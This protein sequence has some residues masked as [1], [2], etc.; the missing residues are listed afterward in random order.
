[1]LLYRTSAGWVVQKGDAYLSA[2]S[3]LTVRED[4]HEFLERHNGKTTGPPR[5]LIAPIEM[6]EVWAAGVTYYRSRSA[7]MAESEDAGGG[8]FY[9]R[10]YQAPRPELFMKNT[11]HRVVG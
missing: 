4:L 8:S 10:V 7:R 6:Q 1:M 11:P 3:G 5:D 9:D 2:P